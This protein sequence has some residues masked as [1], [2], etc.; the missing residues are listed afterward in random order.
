MTSTLYRFPTA[1][2]LIHLLNS[3][4]NASARPTPLP[5]PLTIDFVHTP[6]LNGASL[7]TSPFALP[8]LLDFDHL[9]CD[10][11]ETITDH[12]TTSSF[13][14]LASQIRSTAGFREPEMSWDEIL[15]AYLDDLQKVDVADLCHL[16]TDDNAVK[17]KAEHGGGVEQGEQQQE[18]QQGACSQECEHEKHGA[19]HPHSTTIATAPT[20]HPHSHLHSQH[21]NHHNRLM[22]PSVRELKCH[23]DGRTFTP[24]PELPVPKLPSLQPWIRSQVRKRA[25]EKV[26]LDRV[27]E[28]GNLVGLTR[29]QIREYGRNQIRLRP[30]MVEFLKAFVKN[31]EHKAEEKAKEEKMTGE[32]YI[33]SVNWSED[34]IRGA[35]DQVFGSEEATGR[36]LPESNLISSNL[37]FFHGDH[38]LLLRRKISASAPSTSF[39][40]DGSATS[41]AFSR[42]VVNDSSLKKEAEEHLSNGEVKVQ[43]LT[44]TDKLHAFIKL[45]R[46]YAARHGLTLEDTKWAYLGDSSTDLGC[47]VEAD[48]G[49]IIGKSKSLLTDC[50]RSGVQ[51]IDLVE[52]TDT[53]VL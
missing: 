42:N 48:V 30:G 20:G 23:I 37:Q 44:G 52:R 24:E 1:E 17:D 46:D 2:G 38:E 14:I 6:A 13:D 28:S 45:K 51:V 5:N 31:R 16:N 12:D 15:K 40:E 50:E 35:M 19:Q 41:E 26:S 8:G 49:I 9:V 29:R 4:N 34:L 53:A 21:P 11:D 7:N 39:D 25:V 33:V 10:F 22:A 32:L 36:Y 3:T 27:Y 47:L 43:C 18:Q